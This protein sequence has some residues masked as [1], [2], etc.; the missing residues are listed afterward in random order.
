MLTVG[1]L[2]GILWILLVERNAF[3]SGHV[4][5]SAAISILDSGLGALLGG[6]LTARAAFVILHFEYFQVHRAEAFAFW[7]GGLTDWAAVAGAVVTVFGITRWRRQPLWPTLDSLALPATF[8]AF[9]LWLGCI[10]DGCA[11]GQTLLGS[12]LAVRGR[13]L[14]GNL[15]SRWPTQSTGAI[16][17]ALWLLP[18]FLWRRR[19]GKLGAT[20]AMALTLQATT[21]ALIS[22]VR[23]D[24]VTMVGNLRFDSLAWMALA[25]LGM[26]LFVLRMKRE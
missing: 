9:F 22:F 19:S 13:D 4:A 5:S 2:V 7:Q 3:G 25:T 10:T 18:V 21:C 6:L 20:G 1:S 8:I 14:F 17:S 23:A 26:A 24:P 11:Y 12:P 15:D 16:L